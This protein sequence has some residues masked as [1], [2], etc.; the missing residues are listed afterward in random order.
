[1]RGAVQTGVISLGNPDPTASNPKMQLARAGIAR[2]RIEM[3]NSVPRFPDTRTGA[4]A[5]TSS[6]FALGCTYLPP[7][8]DH[9]PDL[10]YV[11]LLGGAV[12]RAP[13]FPCHTTTARIVSCH[14]TSAIVTN[15]AP[16]KADEN[17]AVFR[18]IASTSWPPVKIGAE[19]ALLCAAAVST[20][21]N[22]VGP[23]T[24]GTN[25]PQ[26]MSTVPVRSTTT[27]TVKT[28]EP[29]PIC[30]METR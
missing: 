11:V 16:W 23:R 27:I 8:L 1:M 25:Y 13:V 9:M 18:F 12:R 17:I 20:G 28:P 19:P 22:R 21:T 4:G 5:P 26:R 15:P 14:H 29:R 7:L 30:T 2:K 10:C 3:W 6:D 24:P